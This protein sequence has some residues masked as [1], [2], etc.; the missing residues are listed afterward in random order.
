[1][2]LRPLPF[3]ELRLFKRR[4]AIKRLSSTEDLK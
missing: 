3:G 4:Q 2:E 1:M